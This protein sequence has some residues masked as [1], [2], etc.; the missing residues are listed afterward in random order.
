MLITEYVIKSLNSRNRYKYKYL[1]PDI[2]ISGNIVAIPVNKLP[3]NS[4]ETILY[5]CDYCGGAFS[6]RYS[7]YNRNKS[8]CV[9]DCCRSCVARKQKE[10][11]QTLYGVDNISFVKEIQDKKRETCRK[12]HGCDWPMQSESV[13]T[14]SEQTMI[15]R[16]GVSHN[17]YRPEV[18][19]SIRQKNCITRYNNG[20]APTS[21]AQSHIAEI[22]HG[23]LNY[24]EPPYN[25]DILLR[26][27]VYLEYNGSGHDLNVQF[28][29]LSR[30]DFL[31]HEIYRYC[32]LKRLGYKV[33]IIDNYNDKLPDDETL[34]NII[35]KAVYF[36][37]SDFNSN[38][39]RIDLCSGRVK[40]KTTEIFYDM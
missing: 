20:N 26:H 15:D 32:Y 25:L 33:I 17:V 31:R 2:D 13:R 7:D 29:Q 11:C 10:S 9:K 12:N 5:K 6:K 1:E 16:Y 35:N 8:I 21:K 37:I 40:T 34:L 4:N 18:I 30:E 3:T 39:I 19:E 24:P 14:K 23:I 36:L 27:N 38:W 22:T 28:G